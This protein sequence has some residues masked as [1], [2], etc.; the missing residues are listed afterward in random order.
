MGG[1]PAWPE[2][3]AVERCRATPSL[4]SGKGAPK[5][6]IALSCVLLAPGL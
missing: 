3:E 5:F 2:I 1:A 4:T 6:L